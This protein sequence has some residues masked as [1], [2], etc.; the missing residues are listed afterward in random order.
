MLGYLLVEWQYV[1][2]LRPRCSSLMGPV[3]SDHIA[4]GAFEI[5]VRHTVLAIACRATEAGSCKLQA[6]LV[7]AN[8]P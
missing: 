3:S 5:A 8:S 4:G 7:C 6:P 1:A 2:V